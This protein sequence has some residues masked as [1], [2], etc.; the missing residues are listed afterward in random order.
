VASGLKEE[1]I[2]DSIVKI[3]ADEVNVI[4]WQQ[5]CPLRYVQM[6]RTAESRVSLH[7]NIKLNLD[8]MREFLEFH[9]PLGWG[10][11]KALAQGSIKKK[12]ANMSTLGAFSNLLNGRNP[13]LNAFQ[14]II[15]V[16]LYCN[17][18]NKSAVEVLHRLNMCASY[19]HLREVLHQLSKNM[20]A[21]L[22]EDVSNIPM[23]ITIDNINLF[24]GGRDTTSINQAQLNNSTGG[25]I[26]SV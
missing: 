19:S 24:S 9:A 11:L 16:Y 6:D 20:G 18:L 23:C 3:C 8:E 12:N 7:G 14:T 26:T 5:Q 22:K 21:R 4:E 10:V 25:Y 17:G 2:K 13:K 1:M 15:T